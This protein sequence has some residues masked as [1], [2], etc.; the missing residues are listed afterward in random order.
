MAL[1]FQALYHQ[2]HKTE[3]L[4]IFLITCS[5]SNVMFSLLNNNLHKSFNV[6]AN[7]FPVFAIFFIAVKVVMDYD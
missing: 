3:Y 4:Q 1:V 2:Q 5:F 7:I 6:F